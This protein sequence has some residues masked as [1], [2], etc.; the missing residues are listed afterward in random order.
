MRKTVKSFVKQV[1]DVIPIT[2]PIYE[3]GALQVPWH[4]G[5]ADLRDLFPNLQYIGRYSNGSWCK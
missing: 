1:V 3:F 4:E 2:G 5:F